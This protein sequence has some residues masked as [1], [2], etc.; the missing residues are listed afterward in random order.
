MVNETKR[1]K[2]IVKVEV[3]NNDELETEF[4]TNYYSEEGAKKIAKCAYWA[5]TNG[6]TVV[7]KPVND[8]KH[9]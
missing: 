7:T 6:Y 5:L 8:E 1:K 3:L 9:N 2:L 4:Y